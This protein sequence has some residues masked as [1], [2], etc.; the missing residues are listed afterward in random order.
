MWNLLHSIVECR[1]RERYALPALPRL[2]RIILLSADL[3]LHFFGTRHPVCTWPKCV[4]YHDLPEP[5]TATGPA[6][7]P[8][9]LTGGHGDPAFAKWVWLAN[10]SFRVRHADPA[11]DM[12]HAAAPPQH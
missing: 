11:H 6:S 9:V 1:P 5:S 7:F 8:V 2:N 10:Y 4:F 3:A 12:S